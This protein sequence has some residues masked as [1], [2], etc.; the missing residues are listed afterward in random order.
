MDK[1]HHHQL[2]IFRPRLDE[3]AHKAIKKSFITVAWAAESAWLSPGVKIPRPAPLDNTPPSEYWIGYPGP[4]SVLDAKPFWVSQENIDKPSQKS[5]SK[6]TTKFL[7][8][9][10][11]IHTNNGDQYF[12]LGLSVLLL[13]E[14]LANGCSNIVIALPF[15]NSWLYF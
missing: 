8:V 3:R 15:F 4:C 11:K 10:S 7:K 13:N 1:S 14:L 5:K 12:G 2:R 9:K 6:P